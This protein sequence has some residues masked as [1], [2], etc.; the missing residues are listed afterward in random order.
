MIRFSLTLLISDAE[1][2]LEEIL[3]PSALPEAPPPDMVV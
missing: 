2:L 1:A 3:L